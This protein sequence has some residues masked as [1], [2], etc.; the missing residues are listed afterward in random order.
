M[1]S[2]RSSKLVQLNFDIVG[3]EQTL[4]PYLWLY[5][6]VTRHWISN[7]LMLGPRSLFYAFITQDHSHFICFFVKYLKHKNSVRD[8]I[9]LS[10]FYLCSVLYTY[11]V[12]PTWWV[13]YNF[14]R[15][16]FTI[17]LNRRVRP[18]KLLEMEVADT[19]RLDN[20][21]ESVWNMGHLSMLSQY[22]PIYE[23]TLCQ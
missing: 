17:C 5:I 6:F 16:F 18:A 19:T 14:T 7:F 10:R 11:N 20:V 3:R 2:R 21:I 4:F 1:S 13:W 23:Y 22:L 9:F 8:N 12:Y 15:H